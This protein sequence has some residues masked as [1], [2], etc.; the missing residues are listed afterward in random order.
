MDIIDAAG[1]DE[2]Y[3]TYV[4]D[5]GYDDAG[6]SSGDDTGDDMDDDTSDDSND[7]N[8]DARGNLYTIKDQGLRSKDQ[9][10]RNKAQGSMIKALTLN[11]GSRTKDQ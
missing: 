8:D 7:A 5:N 3:G 9:G 2:T 4:D 10:P 6:H 1:M 11:Q